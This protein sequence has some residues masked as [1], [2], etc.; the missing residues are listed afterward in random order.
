MFTS[1]R[2]LFLLTA[3][4]ATTAHADEAR[5]TVMSYNVWKG[6]SQVEDGF[7]KGIESIKASGADVIGLQEA[8]PEL[9]GKIAAELGWFREDK[10]TGSAQIVSRY[11]I[12][13][14]VAID[15]LGG[16]LIR[17]SENPER[18]IFL[19][20]CHLDYQFY[21]P[22]AALKSGATAETVLL[23]ENR[24]KRAP[25]MKAM[26]E[27]MKS[28][29]DAADTL[30]IFL[31]GDFNCPSHLDW[32]AATADAHGHV[33]AVAWPPSTQ[34]IAAGMIDSF[35]VSHP[36]PAKE[37]GFTWS[38]IHKAGEPQDRIDF[39][40]HKGSGVSVKT[41]RIFT[42]HVEATVGPWNGSD[43]AIVRKNTWP[44]DHSAVVT[45]YLLK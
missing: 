23:E 31:T 19:F 27:F 5:V 4:L 22:Y 10:S 43:L 34:V 41:S 39:T 37:P 18:R 40:Y 13:E 33:G 35:R 20:N 44:S 2:R 14:S 42:T 32:T 45:E 16:A 9:A 3:I 8:S 1:A 28:R 7:S 6:W 15:R 30:P 26:L 38:S 24:S 17:I 25:Q 12:L 36:D 11:P 21:G 29:L